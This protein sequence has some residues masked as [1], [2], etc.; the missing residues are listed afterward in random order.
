MSSAKWRGS[1][2][3]IVLLKCKSLVLMWHNFGLITTKLRFTVSTEMFPSAVRDVFT[4]SCWWR[5]KYVTHLVAPVTSFSPT[6]NRLAGPVVKASTSGAED[7]GFESRLQ[8]DFSAPSHTSDLKVATQVATLPG[9]WHYKVSAGT[10]RPGVSI[11]WV[12]EVE[13]LICNFYLSVA[14]RKIVCAVSS[15]R[16]ACCW[17]V[18]QLTNKQTIAHSEK[19]ISTCH[20]IAGS[21]LDMWTSLWM[22]ATATASSP[23]VPVYGRNCCQWGRLPSYWPC[24]PVWAAGQQVTHLS[25]LS[26]CPI[27]L[28][29]VGHHMTWQPIFAIP[30]FPLLFSWCRSVPG[31]STHRCYLPIVFSVCPFFSHLAQC[32]GEMSW[33]GP[34]I[35]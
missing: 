24:V 35:L 20:N 5:A 15:L 2:F 31:L 10:G 13:S 29:T 12:G 17:D 1:P 23:P 11:L 4:V 22:G 27:I 21:M 19:H 16:Y 25:I 33:Q 3:S 9:T 6:V 30:L 14:A 34:K 7:Q 26:I 8:R 32:P 18:K 28:W